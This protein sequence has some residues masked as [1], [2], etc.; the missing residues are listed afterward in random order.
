MLGVRRFR[1]PRPA[2]RKHVL[3][4]GVSNAFGRWMRRSGWLAFTLPLPFL[5]IVFYW[6][7]RPGQSLDPYVRVH[8]FVHVRQDQRLFLFPL[9]YLAALVTDGGY[10]GNRFER[11]A[12]RIEAE[13]RATGLPA[14]AEPGD[15]PTLH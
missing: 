13:A 14:W 6:L 12:A 7:D 8:E 3:E 11:E 9:R 1:L 5:V 2:T 15:G 10:R 4:L